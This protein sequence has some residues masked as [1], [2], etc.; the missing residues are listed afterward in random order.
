MPR[1]LRQ[2]VSPAPLA[3]PVAAAQR[4]PGR[5]PCVQA[6]LVWSA[7]IGK[8]PSAALTADAGGREAWA[9]RKVPS[10]A[11]GALL[12]NDV[13]WGACPGR[14]QLR[15]RQGTAGGR[16]RRDAKTPLTGAP[17]WRTA[18]PGVRGRG[19]VGGA[20]RWRAKKTPRPVRG[21]RRQGLRLLRPGLAG[22]RPRKQSGGRCCPCRCKLSLL[23]ARVLHAGSLPWHG[24]VALY[25]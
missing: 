15:S 14:R 18:W 22:R 3:S 11:S 25:I 16:P 17:C 2:P 1:A 13:S 4:T 9:R 10:Q 6:W 21:T 19:A 23:L 12:A 5:V 7:C 20:H 24:S 8:A